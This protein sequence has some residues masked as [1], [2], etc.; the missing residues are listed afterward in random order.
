[1]T[2][3]SNCLV[4]VVWQSLEVLEKRSRS[5]VDNHNHKISSRT[6]SILLE[7]GVVSFEYY[8]PLVLVSGA[9]PGLW[10]GCPRR[11]RDQM[12][13]DRPM[14]ASRLPLKHI[15]GPTAS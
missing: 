2:M 10:A 13:T 6:R 12:K 14:I 1:M 15:M 11:P 4:E 5:R 3:I 7:R 8:L 9:N